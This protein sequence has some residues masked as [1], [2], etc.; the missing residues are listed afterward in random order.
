MLKGKV[1]HIRIL[2]VGLYKSRIYLKTV[3]PPVGIYHI[4]YVCPNF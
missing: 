3:L 1:M 2:G 4:E